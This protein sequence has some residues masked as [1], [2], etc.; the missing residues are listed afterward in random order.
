MSDWGPLLPMPADTRRPVIRW[1]IAL[2]C[3]AVDPAFAAAV[4]AAGLWIWWQQRERP[5]QGHR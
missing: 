5:P 2:A 3:L 4:L 1:W